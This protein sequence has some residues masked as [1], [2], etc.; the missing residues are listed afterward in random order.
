M[1]MNGGGL[2]TGAVAGGGGGEE[3]ASCLG[4]MVGESGR[5][6]GGLSKGGEWV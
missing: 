1:G 5:S 2:G 4:D 6:G 3:P